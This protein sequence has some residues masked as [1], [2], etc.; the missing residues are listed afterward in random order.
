[1]A[2]ELQMVFA[3][4]TTVL[5]HAATLTTTDWTFSGKAGTTMTPLDNSTNKYPYAKAVLGIP[6]TLSAAITAGSTVDLYM[7]EEDIDGA[8]DETPVPATSQSPTTLAKYVGSF[9]LDDQ[10]VAYIKPIVISLEGVQRANF[11]ILNNTSASLTYTSNP[12]TVKITPF[13]Y[14]P[15][16]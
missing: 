11:Y 9:V 7:T 2:N 10:D 5:S 12:I 1:M 4:T 15:A 13:T 6:D 14:K 16:A 8:S 3:S